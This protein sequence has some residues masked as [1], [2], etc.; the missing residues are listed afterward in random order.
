M[1]PVSGAKATDGDRSGTS[2]SIQPR[3]PACPSH[4]SRDLKPI[5]NTG[6]VRAAA[7]VM[8]AA[9]VADAAAI[10]TV[11]AVAETGAADEAVAA[12]DAAAIVAA[13]PEAHAV[14]LQSR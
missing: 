7:T 11:A 9:V 13:A 3:W 4:R 6:T 14:K 5:A 12:A 8:A 10:A 1:M 2:S